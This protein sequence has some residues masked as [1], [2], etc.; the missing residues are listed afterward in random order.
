MLTAVT[1]PLALTVTT[2]IAVALPKEPTLEFTVSKVVV[3]V[4]L[5]VPSKDVAVASTSP[6][7][8]M[9]RA[10]ANF[11]AV[12]ALPVISPVTERVPP[13]VALPLERVKLPASIVTLFEPETVT[14]P[15]RVVASVTARVPANVVFAPLKV[16]DVV[17]PD[18]TIR[19]LPSLVRVPKVVPASFSRTSP[20]SASKLISPATSKVRPPV[21]TSISLSDSVM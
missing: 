12:D 18:F 20:P 6:S 11:V 9:V 3:R 2:G 15:L 13:I 5:P 1:R 19:L 17:D 21:D 14:A 10:V 16:I 7:I 4:M 8:V